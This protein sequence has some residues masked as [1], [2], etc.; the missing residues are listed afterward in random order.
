MNRLWMFLLLWGCGPAVSKEEEDL[1]LLCTEEFVTYSIRIP[2]DPLSEHYTL[3]ISTQD[4]LIL[5]DFSSSD[6]EYPVLNDRFSDRLIGK[7]E[8]FHFIGQQN[9]TAI[10]IPYV[11]TSD[12]CHIVKV[13]G[14]SI[15]SN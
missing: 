2:G 3:R 6:E 11:F 14:P 12:R 1:G 9:N 13:S 4:T 7:Q 8:E 15:F 5:E 10:V